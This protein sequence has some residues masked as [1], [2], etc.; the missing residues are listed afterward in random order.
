MTVHARFA[1]G[2]HARLWLEYLNLESS[3]DRGDCED[4]RQAGAASRVAA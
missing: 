4:W 2:Q 1:A 3:G